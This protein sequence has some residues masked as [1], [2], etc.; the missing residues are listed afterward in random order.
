VPSELDFRHVTVDTRDGAALVG[1]MIDENA[2]A[3]R[4][5]RPECTRHAVGGRGRTESAREDYLPI[6]NFN[7]NP[8]AMFFGEKRL[9]R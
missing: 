5:A 7:G 8:A 4:R 3:V 2:R 1:A 6:G 9:P